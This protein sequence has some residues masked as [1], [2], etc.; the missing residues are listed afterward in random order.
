MHTITVSAIKDINLAALQAMLGQ[1]T[2]QFLVTVHN[3]RIV[4]V[5]VVG[6]S[7]PVQELLNGAEEL[8]F[9]GRDGG[10]AAA[11]R[12]TVMDQNPS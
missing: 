11:G 7:Q 2:G 6:K 8:P 12:P 10:A 9:S 4:S 5:A 1:V 3:K